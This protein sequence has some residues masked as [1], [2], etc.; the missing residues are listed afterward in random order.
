MKE[1]TFI[2]NGTKWDRVED[3]DPGPLAFQN[4]HILEFSRKYRKRSSW[5]LI[6]VESSII[7]FLGLIFQFIES[8][9]KVLAQF[10]LLF[11][12]FIMLIVIVVHIIENRNQSKVNCLPKVFE[13][14]IIYSQVSYFSH[15]MVMMPYD[16]LKAIQ[17]EGNHV[18]L[19]SQRSMRWSF[20]YEEV[21]DEGFQIL[22]GL[23][24]KAH[25]E[26]GSR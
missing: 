26:G 1:R 12:F 4:D 21:G 19:Q 14:S 15:D 10:G 7:I 13:R 5:F 23:F 3:F 24:R 22:M 11:L 25:S 16:Q 9:N 8:S 17:R 2:L 20:R 6:A 18:T